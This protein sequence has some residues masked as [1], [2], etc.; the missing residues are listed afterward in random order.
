MDLWDLAN[1]LILMAMLG[2][3]HVIFDYIRWRH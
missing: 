3:L 2:V 1:L